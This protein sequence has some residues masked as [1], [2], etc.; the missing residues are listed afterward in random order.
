[1]ITNV[2][3]VTVYVHDIDESKAFYTD[4]LGF[5]PNEDITVGTSAGAPSS[6]RTIRSS[7][8]F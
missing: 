5:L 6:R 1:V 7:S 4:K 8:W 3:L 2:A